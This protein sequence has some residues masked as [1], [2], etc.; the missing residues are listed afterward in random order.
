[1][2][3]AVIGKRQRASQA[4][5]FCHGRG[6]RCRRNITSDNDPSQGESSCLACQDYGVDCTVL[7]TVKKRGRKP[8]SPAAH[9]LEQEPVD[10]N[11]SGGV[12]SLDTIRLLVRIYCDTMYQC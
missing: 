10:A 9:E 1:M 3:R 6:L 5:D 12:H 4:C 7:R 2:P 8:K 11:L